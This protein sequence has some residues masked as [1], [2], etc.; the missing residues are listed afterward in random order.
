ML[1]TG[2]ILSSILAGAVNGAW[3]ESCVNNG[4]GCNVAGDKSSFTTS[5]LSY[6]L[7][8]KVT[9]LTGPDNVKVTY[10]GEGEIYPADLNITSSKSSLQAHTQH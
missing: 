2:L 5:T 4:Q 6:E 3:T 9:H 7:D 1:V 8:G 10:G